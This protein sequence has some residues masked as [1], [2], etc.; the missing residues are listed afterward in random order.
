[1]TEHVSA[2]PNAFE[3]L[4]DWRN[5]RRQTGHFLLALDFDGTLAPIVPHPDDAQLVDGARE[6]IEHVLN[7][8]DTDVALV[9]GRALADLRAR[10][11]VPGAY[12][13]GNHG[14]QIDGPEVHETNPDAV[15]LLP[16]VREFSRQ[17]R[18]LLNGTAGVFIEDK[19]LTLSVHYRPVQDRCEQEK[20]VYAVETLYRQ[21]PHGLR[22]TYG[23]KVVEVRPDIDWNKG[24]ATLYLITCIE[25]ARASSVFPIF[26]GDDKTDEDAFRAVRTVGGDGVLVTSDSVTNSDASARVDSVRQVIELIQALAS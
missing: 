25:R 5:R 2:I 12:Y 3:K 6:A 1:L 11:P 24:D 7:R 14:L 9:S 8:P 17:I 23:K 22:L 15:R 16:R 20:I 10:C 18:A 26:I 4:A 19:E 13:S 21:N